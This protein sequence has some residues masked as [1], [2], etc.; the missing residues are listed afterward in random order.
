MTLAALD[1][2]ALRDHLQNA[3][4]V[5]PQRYYRVLA[6]RIA[7]VWRM[8]Q[9]LNTERLMW[10]INLIDPPQRLLDPALLAR[11]LTHRS[12]RSVARRFGR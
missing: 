8:N 2:L 5:V 12:R 10:V 7:P 9:P 11:A 3:N 4:H 1:A 6:A